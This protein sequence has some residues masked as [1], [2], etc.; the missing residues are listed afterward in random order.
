MRT[1]TLVIF[2]VA[3]NRGPE[4]P[5]ESEPSETTS[6]M[7]S[8]TE[9]A[10]AAPDPHAGLPSRPP[11]PPSI[12]PASPVLAAVRWETHEPL[13]FRPPTRPMRN[14]E[15]AVAGDAGEAVM[16]VFHFP[17]MGGA[18]QE[19]INRWVGQFQ[20]PQGG[21]VEDAEVETKT[22]NGFEVTTVDVTGVFAGMGMGGSA[23]QSGTRMLGAIVVGPEGPIFFK[24]VGP[25][26]TVAT[27]ATAFNDL[28]GSF[29]PAG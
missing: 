21:P 4:A 26:A 22:V 17:R 28:I 25:E 19:N 18:V 3:C 27:A 5:P 7:E 14:A 20:T 9:S 1:A 12:D 15:Y 24:L 10:M 8:M 23:P 16:T 29:E 6:A 11:A 13:T 2:L